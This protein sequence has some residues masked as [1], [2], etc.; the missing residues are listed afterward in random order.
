MGKYEFSVEI[1]SDLR[2]GGVSNTDKMSSPL[3]PAVSP[4]LQAFSLITA[5]YS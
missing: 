3:Q 1:R 2:T 4:H 5:K